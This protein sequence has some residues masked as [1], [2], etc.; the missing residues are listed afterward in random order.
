VTRK[1]LYQYTRF[2]FGIASVPALWQTI[3]QILSDIPGHY[4]F[5][6][7]IMMGVADADHLENLENVLLKMSEL[8]SFFSFVFPYWRK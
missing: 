4:F 1:G 2:P 8:F 6:D 3:D 7:V 5:D